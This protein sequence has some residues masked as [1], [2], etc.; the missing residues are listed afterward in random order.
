MP[1][2]SAAASASKQHGSGSASMRRPMR[3]AVP[4]SPRLAQKSPPGLDERSFALH[5]P[6]IRKSRAE[7]RELFGRPY[8]IRH[9]FL[10]RPPV[11]ATGF[12]QSSFCLVSPRRRQVWRAIIRSSSVGSRGKRP[13]IL[14]RCGRRTDR[15]PRWRAVG[16]SPARLSCHH[17]VLK[18]QATPT[19]GTKDR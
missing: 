14:D 6:P 1:P 2:R 3:R 9:A 10:H 16:R 17:S 8:F 12:I 11:G 7:L 19:I 4:G 15:R 5:D 13:P 18:P